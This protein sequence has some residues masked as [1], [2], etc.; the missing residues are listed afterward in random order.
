MSGWLRLYS[1]EVAR[2]PVLSLL[3]RHA[4]AWRSQEGDRK[5]RDAMI[6]SHL[7]LVVPV[8]WRYRADG[9][10]MLDLV[11]EG[12]RALIHAVDSFSPSQDG[13]FPGYATQQIKRALHER[14][15]ATRMRLQSPAALAQEQELLHRRSPLNHHSGLVP[16]VRAKKEVCTMRALEAIPA[17]PDGDESVT[18]RT[19]GK[20]FSRR[21]STD[22]L[23]IAGDVYLR[24]NKSGAA[25]RYYRL[26]LKIDPDHA[27]GLAGLVR[28]ALGRGDIDRARKLASRLRRSGINPD[29]AA[30]MQ[31]SI[32]FL[33]TCLELGG[34]VQVAKQAAKTPNDVRVLY[35]LAMCLAAHGKLACALEHLSLI[36]EEHGAP[37]RTDVREAMRHVLFVAQEL[38]LSVDR[39]WPRL[40]D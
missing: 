16:V 7:R 29:L 21:D 27:G 19:R 20:T 32:G 5:A 25:E 14:V 39:Y 40:A 28:V 37:P 36:V 34:P 18:T 6:R 11:E 33:R 9:V 8:A 3:E 31:C 10:E 12:N 26:A 38:G 30:A 2:A 4:L 1:M 22:R 24:W 13:E 35:A 17:G 15:R 23:S